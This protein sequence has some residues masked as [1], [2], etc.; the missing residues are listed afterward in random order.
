MQE[1]MTSFPSSFLIYSL[2]IRAGRDTGTWKKE[3][4][5]DENVKT[6]PKN[7]LTI[8]IIHDASDYYTFKH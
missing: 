5:V 7:K 6:I 4:V 1:S 8:F 3:T 2:C